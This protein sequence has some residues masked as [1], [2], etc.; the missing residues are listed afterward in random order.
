[1]IS[2]G[3]V[4]YGRRLL[5]KMLFNDAY[6]QE[7][8]K[9]VAFCVDRDYLDNSGKFCGLPQIAF[10]DVQKVYPPSEFDMVA[11][12]ASIEHK[13]TLF[14][15]AKEKGY[16]LRNYISK[17]SIV[18][19][20]IKMGENN[21]IFEQCYIGPETIMQDNNIIRQLVYIGHELTMGSHVIITASTTIGGVCTIEDKVFIGLNSTIANKIHIKKKALIGA[22]TV[23]IRDIE[24][25]TKNVGNPSHSIGIR[26]ND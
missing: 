26:F 4:V 21:I 14:D 25:N 6:D 2:K 23:V 11:L 1:M 13:T 15:R 12:D 16:L 10:E 8:F 9:I 18:S 22:G 3:I 20:D 19:S 17:R 24:E 7:N 5:S